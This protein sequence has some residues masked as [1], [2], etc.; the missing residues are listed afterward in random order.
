MPGIT[1]L[2][3]NWWKGKADVIN[4]GEKLVIDL[5][6][7]NSIDNFRYSAKKYNYDSQAFIYNKIYGYEMLFLVIDKNTHQ[8][9]LFDCSDDFY[10]RG[11]QKVD[12]AN[13]VMIYFIR[14]KGLTRN[15]F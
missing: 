2:G 3:G 13:D 8:I 11:E 5:K 7:T 14:L 15:N 10:S 6:T 9:G 12:K 4:H 1:H